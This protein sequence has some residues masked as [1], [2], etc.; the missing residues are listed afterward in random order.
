MKCG[1]TPLRRS[2]YQA[3]FTDA[4]WAALQRVFPA[5]VCDFTKPGADQVT[6]EP[7]QTFAAGPGGRP[8][9]AAPVSQV[10]R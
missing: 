10:V 1:L 4:E 3:T 9:P 2:A 8:L 7:W 5:G 6:P